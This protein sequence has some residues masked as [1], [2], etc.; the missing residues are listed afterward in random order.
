M[1]EKGITTRALLA[2][3]LVAALIGVGAAYE[4]LMV[5]GSTLNFDYSL[6]AAVFF[7]S[8]FVLV[9]NPLLGRL[10]PSWGFSRS[11]LATVYIMAMV[12]CVL[13]TVGLV[14][15]L[16][17]AMS[18]G[19]Y[20]ATPENN[21]LNLV[22]PNL[23]SWLMVSDPQGIKDF[24]EGL[25][26]KADIPWGIW[27]RPLA[28]W[29]VLLAGFF[30]AVTAMVVLLRQQWVV[31]ERLLFPM[32]QVPIAMI[33]EAGEEDRRG[34][35]PI[36]RSQALWAG[37]SVPVVFYS[38]RALNQYNPAIPEGIPLWWAISFANGAV[39]IPWTLNYAGTGF[40]Y[41]LSTKLS[42]S[43][44]VMGA[45][46]ITEEVVLSTLG[47]SSGERFF[48]GTS[49]TGYPA[50]QGLGAMLTFALA[51][52]WGGRG[53]F[54]QTWARAWSGGGGD[55]R[56]ILTSRQACLLLVFSL[57]VMVGWL[58]VAGMSWWVIPLLLAVMFLSMIGLARVAAE[59]GL[60]VMVTPLNPSDAVISSLGGANLGATNLGVLGMMIPVASHMRTT[61]MAALMNGLK[62]ADTHVAGRRRWLVGA[63][64]LAIVVALGSSIATMLVLGYRY[65]GINLSYW[66]FGN[67]SGGVIYDFIAY[68]QGNNSQT[69][70]D[71]LGFMGVGALLQL[72]MTLAYQRLL[73]WPLHPL[74]FPIGAVWCTHQVMVSMF[75]AWL[76][77][78]TVLH[79][80]GV[81]LYR[82]TRPFF[83]GLILGHYL[84]GGWWLVIDGFMGMR[85]NYLFF[86]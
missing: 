26:V 84:G 28:A 1:T 79:Y 31:D 82:S 64:G 41:L 46:T 17:P 55:Y 67:A 33:G 61:M 15:Y 53:R 21:W 72:L 7:C 22:I 30:G 13:P 74:S 59:G 50:Y 73:W 25:S 57:V 51:V 85:E 16:I 34:L 80:G 47:V 78:I 56:D 49:P 29:G 83:L 35:A 3:T 69:R 43:I 70:W 62:L 45:L 36:F 9:V 20:F 19:I 6:G 48:Y 23:A 10:R 32:V 42:F 68:H 54:R 38:L 77:K 37:V 14:G 2:G 66:F 76:T 8:F 4:N 60:A 63:V 65:G 86:W 12:A 44:W 75:L 52:L 18:G 40:G 27:V 39:V 5:S 11:E 71:G 24:Y 58:A 81:R